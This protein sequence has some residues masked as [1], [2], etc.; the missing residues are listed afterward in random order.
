M[1][2]RILIVIALLFASV[3][4]SEFSVSGIS[5]GGFM[6][7]QMHVAF[8]KDCIG[9][10]IVAGGPYY[11]AL[12]SQMTALTACMSAPSMLNV[13]TYIRYAEDQAL[14]G[15]I[16]D[17]S[18]LTNKTKG[19]WLFSGTV[20]TVVNQK[21]M[22]VLRDFYVHWIPY[23]RVVTEFTVHAQHSWVTLKDGNTCTYL[24]S[25]Y[26]NNCNIDAAGLIFKAAY[27]D[28]SAS[29]DPLTKNLKTF[30]QSK[31]GDLSGAVL[32]KN[33][34]VYI[35][36]GCQVDQSA[37]K[38]HV[39][40]HGCSMNSNTIGNKFEVLSELNGYA[41]TNNIIVI[42]PQADTKMLYNPQGCWD[43]WGYTS[44]DYANK[45]GSQ[46]KAIY[47]MTQNISEL[48]NESSD[49]DIDFLGYE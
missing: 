6:A 25:P 44:A 32:L 29:V 37:C 9:A 13:N 2:N 35:P 41:E 34:Y 15:N 17:L 7:V 49:I 1:V 47:N 18:N 16:D 28:I 31:F 27:G 19:V 48:V 33:G 12:D 14:H 46:M 24:G 20:D 22:E 4:C 45:K 10:G 23:E 5:S 21:V 30:D 8:S 38:V 40:F 26:I 39:A 42:Y 3:S 43:W 11:C 36:T